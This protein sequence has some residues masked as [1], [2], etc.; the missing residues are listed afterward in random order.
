VPRTAL[1]SSLHRAYCATRPLSRWVELEIRCLL[2]DKK[3][4]RFDRHLTAYNH[5]MDPPPVQY[6]KTTD[7]I[8]V[9]YT[10]SGTGAPF[11]FVPNLTN[12]V[13]LSWQLPHIA[14]WLRALSERFMLVRYD[15]RGMGMSTRG[16]RE[17][18][19]FDA[20]QLDL[21]AVLERLQLR[22]FVLCGQESGGQIA[23]RYAVRHPASVVALVMVGAVSIR[24]ITAGEVLHRTLPEE[25]WDIFLQTAAR[26]NNV[27]PSD[28][29]KVVDLLKQSITKD[30]WVNSRRGRTD[31]CEAVLSELQVPTL[32]IHAR[33]RTGR[34]IESSMKVAQLSKGQLVVIDGARGFGEASHGIR[35]IESFLA[36][37]PPV[38][39]VAGTATG[40]SAR[41]LQVLSLI[42]GGKSNQQIADELVISFN[43]VQRH[44]SHILDKTCLSNRTEAAVYARD[45]GLS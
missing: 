21:E 35:A 28:L 25:D 9:A 16:L 19:S 6:A 43:T 7:G 12:H 42:A 31:D 15:S 14:P 10:V 32:V 4:Y 18:H 2:N 26:S 3:A 5:A 23:V 20:Y 1:E 45:H 33:E 39:E 8:S 13:L 38:P 37:L 17:D 27:P 40:L 44:V 34:P 41:E 29:A 11:V 22:R 36:N 30:D 24:G